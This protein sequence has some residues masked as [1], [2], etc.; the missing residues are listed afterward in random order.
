MIFSTLRRQQLQKRTVVRKE[1]VHDVQ[2][3]TPLH[4]K[5]LCP[6]VFSKESFETFVAGEVISLPFLCIEYFSRKHH[7]Q[8]KI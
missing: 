6:V 7:F 3:S 2:A 5:N 4:S 1:N 8:N